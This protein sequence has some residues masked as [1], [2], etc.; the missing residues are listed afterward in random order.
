MG[1][2][3]PGVSRTAQGT[4]PSRWIRYYAR[5]PH[6]PG[7]IGYSKPGICPCLDFSVRSQRRTRPLAI[8]PRTSLGGPATV[9]LSMAWTRILPCF[10]D[11][12][13]PACV[14]DPT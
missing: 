8:H 1:F 6:F 14:G 9:G 7:R 3:R 13:P 12:V 2:W 4:W 11:P 10:P 5:G